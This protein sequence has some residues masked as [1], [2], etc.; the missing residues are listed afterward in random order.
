MHTKK[1]PLSLLLVLFLCCKTS[2]RQPVSS[3]PAVK[4]DTISAE[5]QKVS[6]GKNGAYLFPVSNITK[7]ISYSFLDVH[8]Y[9]MGSDSLIKGQLLQ[10]MPN[11]DQYLRK[12]DPH[13][14]VILTGA[15]IPALLSI[16]NDPKSYKNATAFCYSPR[17]CFCFYNNRNEIVGFY[18]VCFE[19]T[20]ME[21]RPVFRASRKGGLT[22][23]AADRLK[24][25][26]LAAGITVR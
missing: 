9:E 5:S 16:L 20:R 12:D 17:N 10:I 23:E 25:F 13:P 21:S 4:Q 1:L 11:Y 18:E 15:K 6:F 7:V 8:D 26:C 3:A 22:D 14:K 2:T 19:C 24:K